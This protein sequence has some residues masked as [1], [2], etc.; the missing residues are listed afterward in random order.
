[1]KIPVVNYFGRE[2]RGIR[3]LKQASKTAI[4]IDI[5]FLSARTYKYIYEELFFFEILLSK[6]NLAL[7]IQY[8]DI[9][10]IGGSSYG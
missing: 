5:Y 8:E 3:A 1:M 2:I 9:H 10:T 6:I 7:Y 4:V